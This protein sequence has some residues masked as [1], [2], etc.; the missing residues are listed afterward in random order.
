MV[1]QG[2]TEITKRQFIKSYKG[3]EMVES[4]DC[5]RP[6]GTQYME[7][8]ELIFTRLKNVPFSSKTF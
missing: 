8:E 4:H 5:Q 6:E 2:L 7:L 1:K 3:Q